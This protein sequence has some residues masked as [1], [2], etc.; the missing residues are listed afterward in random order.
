[1][2]KSLFLLF[3]MLIVTLLSF[4]SGS[5]ESDTDLSW[6]AGLVGYESGVQ[7]ETSEGI[8]IVYHISD[9]EEAI[10]LLRKGLKK[11]DWLIKKPKN[12]SVITENVGIFV[13]TLAA[14]K[15]GAK[16]KVSTHGTSD[17]QTLVM[18]LTGGTTPPPARGQKSP[19]LK[20]KTTKATT[21]QPQAKPVRK[22]GTASAETIV[23]DEDGINKT[24]FCEGHGIKILGNECTIK[25]TGQ[26]SFIHIIGNENIVRVEGTVDVIKTPGNLNTVTWQ[27]TQKPQP[28]ITDFGSKN[29]LK[30][31]E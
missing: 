25:V 14:Y 16:L 2:K 7:T 20:K 23:L 18:V 15:G 27:A 19:G 4:G 28:K 31:V 11:R 30:A 26:C 24:I 12:V 29:Q 17:S 8:K 5:Q 1:M 22:K 6:V 13:G 21:T 9:A 10:A 3:S